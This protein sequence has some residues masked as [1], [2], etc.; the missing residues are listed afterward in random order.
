MDTHGNA[1]EKNIG[2]LAEDVAA[3]AAVAGAKVDEARDRLKAAH[4][5]RLYLSEPSRRQRL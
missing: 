4:H 3:T 5:H 2:P 1:D